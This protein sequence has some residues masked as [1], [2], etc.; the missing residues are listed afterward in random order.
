MKEKNI[1]PLLG[2]NPV[3]I[4]GNP[5]VSTK[6]KYNVPIVDISLVNKL[7]DVTHVEFKVYNC[8]KRDYDLKYNRK[9]AL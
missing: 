8:F 2:S 4:S 6:M 5:M 1:L 7:G 9:G 3:D